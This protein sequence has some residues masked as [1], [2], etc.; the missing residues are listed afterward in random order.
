MAL[1]CACLTL[2]YPGCLLAVEGEC[3]LVTSRDSQVTPVS[4]IEIR[5]LYL[6]LPASEENH[7]ASPVLNISERETYL[8]FLKNIMHMTEDGYRR[9]LI[10]RTFRMGSKKINE[11]DSVDRLIEYLSENPGDISFMRKETALNNERI[12]IVQKLW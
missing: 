6:G 12:R 5:R 3:V 7:I 9:K 10:K 11:I 4:M 8:H 1:L 2:F